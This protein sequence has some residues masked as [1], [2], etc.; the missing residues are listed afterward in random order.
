VILALGWVEN[1][2]S[3]EFIERTT[4]SDG[5]QWSKDHL[6]FGGGY[7]SQKDLDLITRI[8]NFSLEHQHEDVALRVFN[9]AGELRPG[10]R[11]V[12]GTPWTRML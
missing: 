10:R 3:G 1:L 6:S 5:I 2:L 9:A 7:I 4:A 8:V 12:E 11:I